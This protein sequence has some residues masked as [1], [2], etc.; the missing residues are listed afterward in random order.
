[1]T[2]EEKIKLQLG[3]LLFGNCLLQAQAEAAQ[4]LTKTLET[5]I[6]KLKSENPT[7]GEN[8]GE[9]NVSGA[10]VSAA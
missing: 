10:G 1:M 6:E 5:E 4:E 7:K 8:D 9:P 2:L 3:E